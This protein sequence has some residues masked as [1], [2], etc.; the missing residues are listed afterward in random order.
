[1]FLKNKAFWGGFVFLTVTA[2]AVLLVMD[3]RNVPPTPAVTA[4]A[5]SASPTAT[6]GC[7]LPEKMTPRMGRHGHEVWHD[8]RLWT[9]PQNR[10]ALGPVAGPEGWLPLGEEA[11]LPDG[12][13]LFPPEQSVVFINPA[14]VAGLVMQV[15][16]APYY[17]RVWAHQG[18][19]EENIQQVL[20]WLNTLTTLALPL[21]PLGV[22]D[23]RPIDVLLTTNMTGKTE[24]VPENMI[25]PTPGP[26]LMV[27]SRPLDGER[28]YQ[29]LG[30]NIVHTF[31]RY[32]MPAAFQSWDNDPLLSSI[33]FQELAAT[34][35]EFAAARSSAERADLLE[36]LWSNYNAVT[37]GDPATKPQAP[38][39]AVMPDFP[40]NP[41]PDLAKVHTP[42]KVFYE[43]YLMPLSALALDS[44]LRAKHGDKGLPDFL[45]S[46]HD[47]TH[48][49]FSAA[50]A[51]WLG[52]EGVT[53]YTNWVTLRKRMPYESVKMA[54]DRLN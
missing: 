19:T 51:H 2:A 15:E 53:R 18:V 49:T 37:D 12:C 43:Y 16:G 52:E 4:S 24:D 28:A 8:E 35:F 29:L 17:Y 33:Y 10:Q 46:I 32:H 13:V 26:H 7:A 21:F 11:T 39:L 25:F 9:Q 5:P 34:W 31:N 54:V 44:A 30:H 23:N 47:G 42:V 22:G 40:E 1:M 36:K 38:T 48:P 27:V 50:L 14:H 45:I 20:G 6:I 3:G 41:A